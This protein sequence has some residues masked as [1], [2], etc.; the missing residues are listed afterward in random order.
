MYLPLPDCVAL[1]QNELRKHGADEAAA[2][3][4]QGSN[5]EPYE[6]GT[7]NFERMFASL[8]M[9]RVMCH[10]SC[11]TYH[12]SP[13]TYHIFFGG[14]GLSGEASPWIVCNNRS[15]PRLFFLAHPLKQIIVLI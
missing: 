3:R 5:S 13:V 8:H 2:D 4:S 15:L 10:V 14:G 6:L 9:S 11:V 12:L 7:R 1:H